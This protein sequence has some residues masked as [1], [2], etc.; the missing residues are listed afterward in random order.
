MAF[1]Y[2]AGLGGLPVNKLKAVELLKQSSIQGYA[3]AQFNLA[4]IYAK[5][6]KELPRDNKQAYAWYSV[7]Y[8]NGLKESGALKDEIANKFT[9][10]EFVEAS[11]LSREYIAKYKTKQM[12]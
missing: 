6:E 10:S 11:I 5:G 3:V 4:Y 7:S 12:Q 2:Y 8:H 1:L 9:S